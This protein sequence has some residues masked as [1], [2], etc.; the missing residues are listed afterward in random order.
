M[1]LL[2]EK[3]MK[4]S[5][6]KTLGRVKS[7]CSGFS[8]ITTYGNVPYGPTHYGCGPG[9]PKDRSKSGNSG[10]PTKR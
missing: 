5:K 3:Y 7:A 10:L 8:R 9:F 1:P 2:R 6:N 4:D